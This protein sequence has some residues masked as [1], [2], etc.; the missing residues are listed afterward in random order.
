MTD[1]PEEM[2][3]IGTDLS[4]MQTLEHDLMRYLDITSAILLSIATVA[5][6]WCVYQATGWGGEQSRA[7]AEASSSRIESTRSYNRA[8]QLLGIDADLFMGW[9]D[10]YNDGDQQLLT[11]YESN[12][13]RDEFLPFLNDWKASRPLTNPDAH[14]NPLVSEEYQRQLFADSIQL[15]GEAEA[16]FEEATEANRTADEYVLSTVIFAS[17]LFFAGIAPKF[18]SSRIQMAL[19][20]MAILAFAAGFIQIGGLPT[21]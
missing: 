20:G 9:V 12:L 21:Q 16:Q 13:M 15:R 19:I 3:P 4:R 1:D 11:F 5:T 2:A 14:P 8:M 10:A 6:A 18:A 17:V 7:Y